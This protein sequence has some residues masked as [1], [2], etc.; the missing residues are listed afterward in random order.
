MTNQRQTIGRYGGY[1]SWSRTS[2]R[3]ARTAAARRAGPGQ[4]DY[5]LERLDP[6]RFAN[7]TEAQRLAAAESARKAWYAQLAF[8]SAKARKK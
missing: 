5:W 8:K 2:D 3:S 1:V 6:E 4:V 7:A